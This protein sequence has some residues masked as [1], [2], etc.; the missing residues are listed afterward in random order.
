MHQNPVRVNKEIATNRETTRWSG[1][2]G[3]QKATGGVRVVE[4]FHAPEERVPSH[5]HD[6]PF[7]TIV[8]SGGYV[9]RR[10][11]RIR[12]IGEGGIAIHDE[13][14]QHSDQFASSPTHLV[15]IEW[16]RPREPSFPSATLGKERAFTR[17]AMD[18][19]RELDH[20]DTLS[21][22]AIESL[23]A[24]IVVLSSLE[25]APPPSGQG[26]LREVEERLRSE[27]RQPLQLDD[28]A[29]AVGIHR[30]HLART[31]RQ[32]FGCT[33]G[34]FLRRLRIEWASER[35]QQGAS[36]AQVAVDAGFADQSHLTRWF[37][38]TTGSTPGAL[39]R[40]RIRS[41]FSG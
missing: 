1:T 21:E 11:S 40:N 6:L 3:R 19:L 41:T 28:L 16:L 15:S 12:E 35:L 17:I 24:E 38:R 4:T 18:L 30:S 36:I 10:R 2:P 29:R 33:I 5:H 39:M 8:V 9:E 31:F 32:R 22:V 37:R 14:D 25:I 27:F 7:A 26:W 13:D 20:G 23:A 34:H